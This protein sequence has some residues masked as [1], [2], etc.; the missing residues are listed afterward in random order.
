MTEQMQQEWQLIPDSN[1]IPSFTKRSGVIACPINQ[2]QILLMGGQ[3][4]HGKY[5]N[6]AF[7]L[8][9]ESEKV[10]K[11]A[12]GPAGQLAFRQNHN[13]LDAIYDNKVVALVQGNDQLHH[14]IEYSMVNNVVNMV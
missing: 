2:T 13:S 8:E 6:D 1:I 14:L 5:K 12:Q 9:T 3:G 10:R 4:K 7:V 11:V